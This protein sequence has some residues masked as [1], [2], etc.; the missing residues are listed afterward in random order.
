M[1]EFK[2]KRIGDHALPLPKQ[3]SD[4]A[5]GFDVSSAVDA[6]IS[7][8]GRLCL[9]TG[10]AWLIPDELCGK[11]WPRSG[12]ALKHGIDTMAGLIDPDYKGELMVVL[13]NHGAQPFEIKA[14]DRIAQ[15]VIEL[16]VQGFVSEVDEI[17]TSARG[18]A[19]FG[20]TGVS[21]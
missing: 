21:A 4:H 7:P 8:G 9:P 14:G 17:D 6:V 11:V 19:G 10:F 1:F 20:S 18:D 2:L 16:R 12:L 5:A 15:L 13:I 3:G